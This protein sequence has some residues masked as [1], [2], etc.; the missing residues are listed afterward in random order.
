MHEAVQRVQK[1]T[2]SGGRD[3]ARQVPDSALPQQF[4]PFLYVTGQAWCTVLAGLKF[5]NLPLAKMIPALQASTAPGMNTD[6]HPGA[7]GE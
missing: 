7:Y 4:A 2:K 6:H 1:T 3:S 5:Q